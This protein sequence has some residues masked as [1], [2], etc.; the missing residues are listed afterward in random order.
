MTTL[1]DGSFLDGGGGTGDVVGASSSTDNAIPRFNGTTGKVIQ[2]SNV[3]ISDTDVMTG[4]NAGGMEMSRLAGSTFSTIQHSQDVFH[5][6]GVVA[7]GMITDD[8]DGTITISAGN[9][10][11]R[12]TD[13]DTAEIMFINWSSEA[14]ANVA[15]TDGSMNYIYIEYNA[16]TPQAVASTTKRTQFN[17]N[18][19]LGTVHRNGTTLHITANTVQHVGDHALQMIRRLADTNPFARVSGGM[20]SETGTRNIAVTS[21]SWWEGVTS[22]TTA[23]FDS[24]GADTFIYY[25]QDG[26]GGFT[27]VTAQSQIDNT[28]YDDGTGT[29][30]TL[31]NNRYNVSWVYIGQDGEM[32]VLYGSSSGSLTVAQD[33]KA[34]S[35]LPPHFAENHARLVGKVITIKSA[36]TFTSIESAFTSEF[37]PSVATDHGSLIGL[38]DDDH[39]QYHNDARALTWLGTRSTSDLPEGTNLYFTGVERTKLTGIETGA[40]ADQTGAEIKT[41]YELELDTNAYTDA[42]KT[43]LAGI[44]ALADVTDTINVTAAG[45]AMTANNL[46]D[47]AV[48]ATA[49]TNIGGIGAATT[50]TLTNKTFDANGVGNSLSNVDLSADVTGTAPVANGGTGATTLTSKGILFGN[51]TTAIGATAVGTSG[52]VLTSNG[53]GV[54]PTF[55]TA[56]GG[57]TLLGSAFTSSGSSTSGTGTVQILSVVYTPVSATSTIYLLATAMWYVNNNT[58]GVSFT[59]TGGTGTFATGSS[60][61]VSQN[62][63]ASNIGYGIGRNSQFSNTSTNAT[64]FKFNATGGGSRTSYGPS[65]LILLEVE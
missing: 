28:Q 36:S 22:F 9:G 55:Q 47:V 57:G 8:T 10:L 63:A 39:T 3:I 14:G 42:E 19:L 20:I 5:S 60:G 65:S 25:Y 34:P 44:E 24:S 4:G 32:Y 16:G 13:S 17:T 49:L 26:I 12:A 46:S 21:G 58:H 31:S 41:A 33:E 54:S 1:K 2:G 18:I 56:A 30:A 52:Q 62:S 35:A 29:L 6:A 43:K 50:D 40:T 37:T 53:T 7:G 11:I 61:T 23:A 38:A 51:G 15:L 48:A 59:Q 64:T 45:A 27:A